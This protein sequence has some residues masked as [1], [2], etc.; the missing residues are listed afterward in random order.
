MSGRDVGGAA[1]QNSKMRE[2]AIKKTF[3]P[4]KYAQPGEPNPASFL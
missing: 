3:R 1:Q 4:Q 2:A